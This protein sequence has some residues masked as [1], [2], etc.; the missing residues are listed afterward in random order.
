MEPVA[1][2]EQIQPFISAS[3]CLYIVLYWPK[4][5]IYMAVDVSY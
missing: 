3:H 1:F 5:Y 4:S 2:V